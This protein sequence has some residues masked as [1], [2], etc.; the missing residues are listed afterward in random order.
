MRRE[1]FSVNQLLVNSINGFPFPGGIGMGK[2]HYVVPASSSTSKYR[3]WLVAN[4]VNP[5]DIYATVTAGEDATTAYRN[6]VVF[7]FPGAY[8]EAAEI[9]WD[10][11]QTHL[12]G[13]G[14]PNSLGD[15]SEANVVIYSDTIT[16]A[17]IIT[18]TGQN[19]IFENFTVSN[20]GNNAACLTAFTLNKYGC[21]FKNVTFQGNMTT[22]QNTT[23]AAASL[24]IGTDGMYP[25][26]EDCVIGQD[27]WGTRS[28]ANSG[29]LRF[30]GTGQ[31]N[32]GQFKRCRIVS[33][34][35]VVT[36][37]AVALPANG[38]IGRGW[39]W[40]NCVFQ[41]LSP[42]GAA[43]ANCNN[44]FYDNDAAGQT[45]LLKDCVGMGYAEWQAG[46]AS[47]D[48]RIFSNMGVAT[49]GGGLN[50]EPTATIS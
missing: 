41:N 7:V 17:S 21:Y 39:V 40:D 20:Y 10:K 43:W 5:S 34:S 35:D 44:V 8:D 31:P 13:C 37:A 9:A 1:Q 14:G 11:P 50:I 24:Y 4:G 6:D 46:G 38:A 45:L 42:A 30:T 26:F 27:C 25:I 48:R 33:I 16:V 32:G 47:A 18:V 19:C 36:C 15:F 23:V 28:G 22:N 49:A 12:I 3:D 29:Q 2:A